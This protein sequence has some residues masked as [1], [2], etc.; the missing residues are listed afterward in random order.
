MRFDEALEERTT[1]EVQFNG[2]GSGGEAGVKAS[3]GR[4]I[5]S[6]DG[7]VRTVVAAIPSAMVR[8]IPLWKVKLLSA[9]VE[10]GWSTD[11]SLPSRRNALCWMGLA[12]L[13]L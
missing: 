10:R 3:D 4:G 8:M 5:A 11:C 6:R 1:L 12:V 2:I 13:I 7:M 9:G